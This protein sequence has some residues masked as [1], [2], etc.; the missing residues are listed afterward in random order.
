MYNFI[1]FSAVPAKTVYLL[2]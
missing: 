2:M 1:K